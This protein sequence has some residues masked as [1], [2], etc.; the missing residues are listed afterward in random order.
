MTDALTKSEIERYAR[1]LV[2]KEIGGPGQQALKR[3]HVAIVGAGGLGAPCLLYLAAAGVGR[4]TIIDDDV[5]ALSNLQR[6]VIHAS[7]KLGTEKAENARAVV[8]ALNPYVD[9]RAISKRLTQANATE[10]LAGAD[11]VADGSDSFETRQQVADACATLRVP[12]VSAAVSVWEGSLTVLAPHLK[13]EADKTWPTFQDLYP[14]APAPG[15]LPTC[16]QVGVVGALT[17]ILGTLQ[18]MEVIKLIT[19][20]GDPLLGRLLLVDALSMRFEEL[21]YG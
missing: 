20:A 5:V 21:R 6:Q 18:A 9:V 13:D 19:D 8:E 14:S 3:S 2:I 7:D 10:L 17:G 4:L 16:A 1:H 12:L 11:I 15:S